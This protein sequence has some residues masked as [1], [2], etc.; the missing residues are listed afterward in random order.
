MVAVFF[1][2]GNE[3]RS[4]IINRSEMTK[5]YGSVRA[6]VGGPDRA[7][8]QLH[9]SMGFDVS[10]IA[11]RRTAVMYQSPFVRGV[12]DKSWQGR[13]WTSFAAISPLLSAVAAVLHDEHEYPHSASNNQN[14]ISSDQT[15][16]TSSAT[17]TTKIAL[18]IA[19]KLQ[20]TGTIYTIQSVK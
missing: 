17:T 14:L 11:N 2:I 15:S 20:D 5:K 7:R 6:N 13:I 1:L 10:P 8:T 16:S 9:L 18:K 19:K 4:E 12:F 3:F